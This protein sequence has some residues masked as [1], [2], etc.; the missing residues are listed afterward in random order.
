VTEGTE[1][2]IECTLQPFDPRQVKGIHVLESVTGH[3]L[4]DGQI[5]GL[6]FVDF[7]VPPS[8]G[9]TVKD[10]SG[11]VRADLALQRGE[12]GPA[13]TF[14]YETVHLEVASHGFAGTLGGQF[15]LSTSDDPGAPR[16][17]FTAHL[18]RA[19]LARGGSSPSPMLAENATFV[20]E[21][22]T[23]SLVARPSQVSA[24]VDLPSVTLPDLSW[25]NPGAPEKGSAPRFTGGAGFAE[26]SAEMTADGRGS[27]RIGVRMKR[28]AVRWRDTTLAGDGEGKI[29]LDSADLLTMK[30]AIGKS[31]LEL[32]DV[33]VQRKG[34]AWPAWWS[35]LDVEEG[36]LGAESVGVTVNARCKDGRPAIELLEAGGALPSWA[37]G[38]T[39]LD[40][41]TLHAS[42]AHADHRLDFQLLRAH[43]GS[44]DV[45]GRLQRPD[46]GHPV[47]AFLLR[48]GAVSAGIAI[49]PEGTGVKL[50]EGD[51]W[52]DERIAKLGR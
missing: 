43:A 20:V 13:S 2:R 52:L 8:S 40:N 12:L 42:I 31:H 3:V 48:S 46:G 28:G 50:F 21:E 18:P 36:E 9:V 17:T 29:R 25:L 39:S 14:A 7:Y 10:G 1:G 22:P 23:L 15:T 35:T 41:V 26:G 47:G 32:R 4:L 30:V 37:G 34:D 49:A 45:R 6:G 24:K 38:L 16:A 33:V 44:L 27:A 19:T 51:A 5:P 11:Q